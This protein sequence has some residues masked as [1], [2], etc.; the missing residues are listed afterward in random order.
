ML[1]IVSAFQIVGAPVS[2]ERYGS[3]HINETYLL[4]TDAPHDYI[5]QKINHHIF[6]DVEGLMGNISAVTSFLYQKT[7]DPR[8]V[9]TLVPTRDGACFA[10]SEEENISVFMNL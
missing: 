4:R 3:G 8:R 9:L 7:P 1:P 6:R 2:C 5:L 10:R